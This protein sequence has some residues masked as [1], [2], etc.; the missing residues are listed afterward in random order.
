MGND[1]T[2]DKMICVIAGVFRHGV[3]ER[4]AERRTQSQGRSQKAARAGVI[5][6]TPKRRKD[7][8]FRKN[9]PKEINDFEL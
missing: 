6:S 9:S 1:D 7:W 2:N 3:D 5:E 8:R 4:E